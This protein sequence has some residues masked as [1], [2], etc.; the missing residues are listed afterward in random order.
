MK[1]I[2]D[3]NDMTDWSEASQ[4]TSCQTSSLCTCMQPYHAWLPLMHH[5][6]CIGSA[7]LQLSKPHQKLLNCRGSPM[8]GKC[9]MENWRSNE[10]HIIKIKAMLGTSRRFKEL[11]KKMMHGEKG[12]GCG[13]PMDREKPLGGRILKRLLI[14]KRERGKER[15]KKGLGHGL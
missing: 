6:K 10:K 9:C 14:F 13:F 1:S 12:L 3:T 11:W 2:R 4:H 8:G 5:F 15:R 7:S